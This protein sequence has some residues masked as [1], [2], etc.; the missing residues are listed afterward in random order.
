M[1]KHRGI[2]FS[3]NKCPNKYYDNA[4][5]NRHVKMVHGVELICK[6]CDFKTS[7]KYYLKDHIERLHDETHASSYNCNLCDFKTMFKVRLQKH[8]KFN[9]K[10]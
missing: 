2:S 1:N 5:L 10:V 3:C 6:E 9:C 8:T 4:Q 7:N